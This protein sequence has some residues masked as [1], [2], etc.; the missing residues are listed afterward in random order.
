MEDKKT[1]INRQTLH[2]HGFSLAELM[3]MI[4]II[5]IMTAI[6]APS[7]MR[8]IPRY[9][10]RGAARDLAGNFQKAKMEAVK[11]G[12]N[13]AIVFSPGT[14]GY[15]IFV[16]NGAGGAP[17]E[18]GDV[19]LNDTE[20]VLATVNLQ[21]PVTL[22]GVTFNNNGTGYNSRGLPLAGRLGKVTLAVPNDPATLQLV[23]SS[24]GMLKLKA[25]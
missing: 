19:T 3:I 10:L 24:A 14:N 1:W 20:E 25:K 18:D 11:R 15:Q 23:F 6:A 9:Q 5:G 4:A 13:V 7:I 8:T 21:T 16:D 17:G 22:S 12:A 2:H